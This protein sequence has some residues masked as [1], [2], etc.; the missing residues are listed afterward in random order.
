MLSGPGLRLAALMA[1]VRLAASVATWQTDVMSSGSELPQVLVAKYLRDDRFRSVVA[2][3]LC[4]VEQP[5]ASLGDRL[6]ARAVHPL[7]VP[8]NHSGA[9]E[10]GRS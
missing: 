7:A 4:G 6:S 2:P 5:H 10:V 3:A 1:A 9:S 8:K